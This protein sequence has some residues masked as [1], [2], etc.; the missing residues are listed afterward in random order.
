MSRILKVYGWLDMILVDRQAAA[1]RGAE[2]TAESLDDG[3]LP[4]ALEEG[5][6]LEVARRFRRHPAGG[7]PYRHQN[8]AGKAGTAGQAKVPGGSALEALQFDQ[9][10]DGLNAGPAIG[11][12]RQ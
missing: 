7:G 4:A 8:A 11:R 1:G 10:A 3:E 5:R 9:G 6:A 12:Q 2:I